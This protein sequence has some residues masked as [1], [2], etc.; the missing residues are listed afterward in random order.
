MST[1]VTAHTGST[2]FGTYKAVTGRIVETRYRDITPY[3]SVR[4]FIIE[5]ETGAQYVTTQSRIIAEVAQVEDDELFE[6]SRSG[7]H[8]LVTITADAMRDRIA[9]AQR[10]GCD[11]IERQGTE[12][13][14]IQIGRNGSAY[15]QYF[16][17]A[18]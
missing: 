10:F 2:K 9:N 18:A 4:E 3:H 12:R 5:D 17:K 14:Y 8:K 11:V 7:D 15:G 13:R 16:R 6:Y 1:T